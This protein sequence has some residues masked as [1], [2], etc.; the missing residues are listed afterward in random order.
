MYGMVERRVNRDKS[1]RVY[2]YYPSFLRDMFDF[3]N[4]DVVDVTT[5]GTQIIITPLKKN[6]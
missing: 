3:Q 6:R 5:N 2:N 4:G 1:N